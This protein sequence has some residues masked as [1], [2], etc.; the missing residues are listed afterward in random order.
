MTT[1]PYVY[2]ITEI[3]RVTDGDTYWLRVDVGF[4]EL[5]L[6]AVRLSGYDCPER[7]SGSTYEKQ[8]AIVATRVAGEFLTGEW[9]GALW[10]RTEKDP[11]SFGRWL[12]EIWRE[13][14]DGERVLLGEV[15]RGQQLA[16]V[17]P[18][19]WREEFDVA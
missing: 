1:R 9:S 8:R 19:R 6:I 10:V 7:Y 2:P 14:D 5:I 4:R 17:W 3:V 12:G 18:T 16:S 15:L 11:D 13:T